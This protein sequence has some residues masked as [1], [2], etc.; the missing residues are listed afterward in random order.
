[1]STL[2][3]TDIRTVLV[4]SALPRE[5]RTV[6]TA[7]FGYYLMALGHTVL[8]IDTDFMHPALSR[9]ARKAPH[10]KG[11]TDVIAGKAT[12]EDLI[13]TDKHGLPILPAGDEALFSPDHLKSA[14][15]QDILTQLKQRYQYILIDTGP[16]LAHAEAESLAGEVDGVIVLVEWL[17]TSRKNI[18]NMLSAMDSTG[19][20][21]LG[22]LINKVD[23]GKYKTLTAG[24]DFLL[25]KF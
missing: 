9:F 15:V 12:L 6:F 5:G 17:K 23:V 20:H 25:P 18:S 2:L 24:S 16:V 11:F 4:T 3:K 7:A 8:V 22:L 21:I 10:T 19:G 14:P 1:M 13:Q